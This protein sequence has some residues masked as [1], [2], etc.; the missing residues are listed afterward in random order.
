MLTVWIA[1][2]VHQRFAEDGRHNVVLEARLQSSLAISNS[3]NHSMR[4]S[5]LASTL[6][7]AFAIAGCDSTTTS[8]TPIPVGINQAELDSLASALDCSPVASIAS[9]ESKDGSLADDDCVHFDESNGSRL[10][11]FGFK[12]D[13]LMDVQ[14]DLM[15]SEL[16]MYLYLFDSVG[17]IMLEDDD[18]GVGELGTDSQILDM[19]EPGVYAIGVNTYIGEP[20]IGEYSLELLV[21]G[22]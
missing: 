7:F 14:I 17:N 20:T 12:I 22:Q 13:E 11:Y 8:I 16:D 6:M 4:T 10:D 3:S 2:R 5:I 21:G 15:S 19:L 9:G 1:R 18:S